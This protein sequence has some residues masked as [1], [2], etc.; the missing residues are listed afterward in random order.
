MYADDKYKTT[1]LVSKEKQ[2]ELK[3]IK[4]IILAVAKEEWKEVKYSE[5]ETPLH[6]GDEKAADYDSKAESDN[7]GR[8]NNFKGCIYFNTKSYRK[9][10]IIGPNR[11][12]LEGDED[13]QS[14]DHARLSLTALCYERP[15]TVVKNGKRTTENLKGVSFS[16]ENLQ[17]VATGKRFTGGGDPKKDFDEID[18]ESLGLEIDENESFEDDEAA[19]SDEGDNAELL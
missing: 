7:V 12:P 5:L 11:E 16:L 6:D 8:F 10:G 14:G 1:F 3:A 4:Q 2:E 9:P 17:K 18:P 13:L 19:S 15:A